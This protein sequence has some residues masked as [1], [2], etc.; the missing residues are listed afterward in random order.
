MA[1]GWRHCIRASFSRKYDSN[2]AVGVHCIRPIWICLEA[3]LVSNGTQRRNGCAVNYDSALLT[4]RHMHFWQ[5]PSLCWKIADFRAFRPCGG[6]SR[7]TGICLYVI[8]NTFPKFYTHR[9][10]FDED[11]A[12]DFSQLSNIWTPCLFWCMF[13]R[14]A[15]VS[16]KYVIVL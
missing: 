6:H 10:H 8:H 14:T 15:Y 3:F 4:R 11:T 5:I 12:I 16:L 7:Y 13:W 1:K 9:L 2:M